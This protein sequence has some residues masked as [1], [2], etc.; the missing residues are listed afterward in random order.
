MSW[1]SKEREP[2]ND[3]FQEDRERDAVHE[4]ELREWDNLFLAATGKY[5]WSLLNPISDSDM[6]RMRRMNAALLAGQGNAQD[7][8]RAMLAMQGGNQLG[9]PYQGQLGTGGFGNGLSGLLGGKW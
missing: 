1:F 2:Q 7:H 6:E 9:N 3:F 5:V 8:Y 4:A